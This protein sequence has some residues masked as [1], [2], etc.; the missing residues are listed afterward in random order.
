MGLPPTDLNARTGEFT[1]PGSSSCASL[2]IYVSISFGQLPLHAR[3]S[4]LQT[5]SSRAHLFGLGGD[6]VSWRGHGLGGGVPPVPPSCGSARRLQM[7][8]GVHFRHLSRPSAACLSR[9]RVCVAARVAAKTCRRSSFY[10]NRGSGLLETSKRASNRVR[11]RRSSLLERKRTRFRT[12]RSQGRRNERRCETKRNQVG[13]T[14]HVDENDDR[15]RTTA[16]SKRNVVVIMDQDHV[17]DETTGPP[18]CVCP[19]C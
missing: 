7:D 2:K 15:H 4:L 11:T 12:N 18:T 16:R 14:K 6:V 5:T 1:P 3:T 17:D 13:A 8:L 9:R 10:P 19:P